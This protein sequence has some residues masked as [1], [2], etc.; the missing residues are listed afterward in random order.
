MA[1][2]VAFRL[3]EAGEPR[4]SYVG[5][6]IVDYPWFGWPIYL[7]AIYLETFSLL[8]AFRPAVHRAWGLG[9]ILMHAGIC[10]ALDISFVWQ[11]HLLALM[12]IASPFAPT[13]ESW[14]AA[15]VATLRD[16]PLL[17]DLRR[18]LAFRRYRQ[19]R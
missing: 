9:L 5:H 7:I 11:V 10:L 4:S 1:R 17:G 19:A 2:H 18:L 3:L 16:F 15:V 6:Y 8:V 14:R 12:L 13:Y